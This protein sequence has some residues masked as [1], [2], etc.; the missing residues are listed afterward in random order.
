MRKGGSCAAGDR[1]ESVS[2]LRSGC[3][4]RRSSGSTGRLAAGPVQHFRES[5][6]V[7]VPVSSDECLRA[8][9]VREPCPRKGVKLAGIPRKKDVLSARFSEEDA[10][11]SQAVTL[12]AGSHPQGW[13]HPRLD[14]WPFG[15]QLNQTQRERP[16]VRA[17]ANTVPVTQLE[18]PGCLAWEKMHV[19]APGSLSLVTCGRVSPGLCIQQ[20]GQSLTWREA[21]L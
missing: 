21:L 11:S 13:W 7:T 1:R 16:S 2:P 18:A 14:S 20:R 19:E 17:P 6:T 10:C 9:C 4:G 8:T 5:C 3:R 12:R 15:D